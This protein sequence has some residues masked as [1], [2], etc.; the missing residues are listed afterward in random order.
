[1]HNAEF[2]EE[3][4]WS[5]LGHLQHAIPNSAAWRKGKG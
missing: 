4:F 2:A 5:V 3:R 1:L